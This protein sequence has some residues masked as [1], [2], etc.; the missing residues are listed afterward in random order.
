MG[1]NMFDLSGKT[2]VITGGG[3][4]LGR[5]FCTAMAEF[6][7]TVVC[8]GRTE[9]KN[10]KTLEMV[11]PFGHGISIVAD[12][13]QPEGIEHMVD[14]IQTQCG[15][16]D[17]F[18]ANA[19]IREKSF[20]PIHEKPIEDWDAVLNVNL[21]SIFLQMR[22]VFP[23][24][25]LQKSGSFITTSSVGGLWPLANDKWVYTRQPM[26]RRNPAL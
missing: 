24:M 7:A 18:F 15:S 23:K 17:I 12:V 22:A 20:V 10:L 9:H 26:Q 21:R 13:S 14:E 19:A 2:A 3:S 25:M 5:A 4:G 16:I 6:G 8:V 11:K 1:K